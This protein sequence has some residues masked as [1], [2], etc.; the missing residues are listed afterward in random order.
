MSESDVAGIAELASAMEP[1]WPGMAAKAK[2]VWNEWFAD[3]VLFDRIGDALADIRQNRSVPEWVAQ[4]T[5]SISAWEYRTRRV[6]HSLR[7]FLS[8]SVARAQ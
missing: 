2:Q 4:R 5:P 1:L 3:D 7:P 8:R 6:F